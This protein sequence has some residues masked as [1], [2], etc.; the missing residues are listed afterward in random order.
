MSDAI[1][2]A[3]DR[4]ATSASIHF[5]PA[6]SVI[7][8]GDRRIVFQIAPQAEGGVGLQRGERAGGVTGSRVEDRA[9]PVICRLRRPRRRRAEHLGT[10]RRQIAAAACRGRATP[11]RP[12]G[13]GRIDDRMP[14]RLGVEPQRDERQQQRQQAVRSSHAE[15]LGRRASEG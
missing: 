3:E 12:C 6:R 1:K 14:R 4:S 11:C 9:R 7:S 10:R 8:I 5:D 15:M 13:G 2:S